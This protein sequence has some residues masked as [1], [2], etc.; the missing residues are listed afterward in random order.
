MA[1]ELKKIEEATQQA[2]GATNPATPA[3]A[4]PTNTGTITDTPVNNNPSYVTD[5][6]TIDKI[7]QMYQANLNNTKTNLEA[8]YQKNLSGLKADQAKI[9]DTYNTQRDALKSAYET[10]RRNNNIQAAVNGLNTGTASQMQLAQNNAYLGNL[11][12]VNKSQAEAETAAQNKITDL[13][14]QYQLDINGAIAE[15]DY[16]KAAAILDEYANQRNVYQ[17]QAQQLANYGDFSG[18]AMLFGQATADT[19][20]RTWAMQNPLLAYNLGRLSAA[21]YFNLTGSYPPGYSVPSS[22]GGYGGGWGGYSG[23]TGGTDIN[24]DG[25]YNDYDHTNGVVNDPVH[26]AYNVQT[27]KNTSTPGTTGNGGGERF[28]T[29]PNP[30]NKVGIKVN[31]FFTKI[32]N[33]LAS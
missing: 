32:A 30:D 25:K 19:M 23:G 11:G 8:A 26:K 9:A 16:Q 31:N 28:Q 3:T 10:N 4:S 24:G 29:L 5:T 17:Q 14:T 1:D 6:Q 13:T 7:G 27:Y 2:A 12:E 15:N 18:Y 33:A 21:E 20:A 22:G